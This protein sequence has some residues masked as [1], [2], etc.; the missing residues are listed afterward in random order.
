LVNLLACSLLIPTLTLLGAALAIVLTK[1]AVASLTVSYCQRQI[2]LIPRGPFIHL[3]LAGG[4]GLLCYFLAKPLLPR[5]L[6]EALAL[7]PILGLACYWW[8]GQNK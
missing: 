6:A 5:E 1:V 4:A 8:R 3:A 7:A 2:S